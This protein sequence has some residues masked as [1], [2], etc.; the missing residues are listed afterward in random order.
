MNWCTPVVLLMNKIAKNET[1]LCKFFI[2]ILKPDLKTISRRHHREQHPVSVPLMTII[3][4]CTIRIMHFPLTVNRQLWTKCFELNLIHK[5][6]VNWFS[7][8]RNNLM[9]KWVNETDSQRWILISLTKCTNVQ[10]QQHLQ[11]TSHKYWYPLRQ[12][13]VVLKTFWAW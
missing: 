6:E 9:E 10:P 4:S 7:L 12:F 8:H 13:P 2:K 3:V 11:D 5:S 1:I